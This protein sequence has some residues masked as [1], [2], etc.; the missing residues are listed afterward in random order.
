MTEI[1]HP[2]F[3]FPLIAGIIIGIGIYGK[4]MDKREENKQ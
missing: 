2:L 3:I 1:L 4:V